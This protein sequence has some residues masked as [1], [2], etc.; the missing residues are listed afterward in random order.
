MPRFYCER[1][2]GLSLWAHALRRMIAF[3]GGY[4]NT[5]DPAEAAFI[6][7][8]DYYKR[9]MVVEQLDSTV[10]PTGPPVPRSSP[11]AWPTPSRDPLRSP[12]RTPA[13][14]APPPIRPKRLSPKHDRAAAWLRTMLRDG[15]PI[16]ALWMLEQAVLAHISLR[17]LRRARTTVRITVT[18]E[19]MTGGWAWA[20][21]PDS[22]GLLR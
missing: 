18:K 13:S 10:V 4:F 11:A 6:R 22:H 8:T 5:T 14:P 7:S 12:T 16:P 19:G 2:S 9:G 20:L 3:Q 1:W 15:R 21:S 17:T